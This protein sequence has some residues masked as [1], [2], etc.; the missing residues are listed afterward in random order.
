MY[1]DFMRP[2]LEFSIQLWGPQH[3]KDI[4]LL[5]QVQRRDTKMI[6]ELEH[7]FYEDRLSQL[8]LFSPRETLKQ[9][10]ST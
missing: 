5:K 10:S 2:H 6:R 4:D 9:P 7:I 1:R 3:K 8:G